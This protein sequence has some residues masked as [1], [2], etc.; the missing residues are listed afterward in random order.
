[1]VGRLPLPPP[2]QQAVPWRLL[3]VLWLRL[4]RLLPLL[5]CFLPSRNGARLRYAWLLLCLLRR[6]LC[7]L[8]RCLPLLL[9]HPGNP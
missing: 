8:L 2:P 3:L 4:L 5:L 9:A 1:V 7:L 6:L